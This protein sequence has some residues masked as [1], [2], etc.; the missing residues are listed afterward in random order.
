M[1]YITKDSGQRIQ[2]GDMVRDTNDGKPRFDLLLTEGIPYEDQFLHRLAML[3]ARGAVK[4]GDRN[5]EQ[6]EYPEAWWRA[7][8]SAFRHL[9]QWLSGEQDE[10][11]AAAAVWNIFSAE[12]YLTKF[13]R[14]N[15]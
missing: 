15:G 3:Y 12:Y 14:D 7:R 9:V 11:H 1:R 8:E 2:M 6:G 13:R 5:Y 10:D 4:Y